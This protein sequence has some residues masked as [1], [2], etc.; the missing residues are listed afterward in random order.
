MNL[1]IVAQMFTIDVVCELYLSEISVRGF[2]ASKFLQ[3]P[4]SV[5]VA[6]CSQTDVE[7][8]SVSRVSDAIVYPPPHHPLPVWKSSQ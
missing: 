1:I 2:L 7:A 4:I 5:R 8:Q 3:W 6:S